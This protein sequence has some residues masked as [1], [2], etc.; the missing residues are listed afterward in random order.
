MMRHSVALAFSVLGLAGFASAQDPP[1]RDAPF[2]PSN[3]QIDENLDRTLQR[4]YDAD[5]PPPP[6]EGPS[7]DVAPPPVVVT[8]DEESRFKLHLGGYGAHLY[9]AI[10]DVRVGKGHGRFSNPIRL[11]G[12]SGIADFDPE[13]SQTYRAWIDFGKHVSIEGGFRRTVF[14]SQQAS[15]QSFSFD[16]LTVGRNEQLGVSLDTLTADLDLVIKPI[17]NR[18][19]ELDLNLG[20]RYLFFRTELQGNQANRTARSTVEAAVPVV[21]AG[22]AL[23]PWRC[24][25][26]F[27]R[28]RV[29]YLDYDRP[30]SYHRQNGRLNR[31]SNQSKTVKTA[32]ID[33]GIQFLIKQ[34]IG[35]IAGWRMDYLQ[36]ERRADDAH[37]E[38]RATINGLYAGLVL[39]F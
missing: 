3:E 20:S 34:H 27:A 4:E 37:E 33:I 38:S 6:A 29:G 15:Q 13:N 1:P 21:G 24:L 2:R 32:E 11:D 5:H 28:G 18:W 36:F 17:N 30:E 12:S 22:I 35:V 19:V 16:R 8:H 26:L 25:E 23:R 31:V 39:Q 14:R 7:G 10:S 9:S